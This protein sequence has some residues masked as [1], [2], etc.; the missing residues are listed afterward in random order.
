MKIV[1]SI[2]PIDPLEQRHYKQSH[3]VGY[4]WE[5]LCYVFCSASGENY[6]FV[7]IGSIGS[8]PQ[9]RSSKTYNGKAGR[10]F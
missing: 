10:N 4:I 6:I 9:R 7:I 8:L 5:K 3:T 2:R 1:T